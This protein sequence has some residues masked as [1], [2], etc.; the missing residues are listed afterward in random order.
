MN[1]LMAKAASDSTD[2][3]QS[4]LQYDWENPVQ[5]ALIIYK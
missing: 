3:R 4:V 5:Q 1:A 2:P